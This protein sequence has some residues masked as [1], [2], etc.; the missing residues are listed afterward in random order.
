MLY[1][2]LHRLEKEGLIESAWRASETSRRRKY[3]R[4]RKTGQTELAR[5]RKQWLAVHTTLNAVWETKL[6]PT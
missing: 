4:I 3:Y 1:P 2:V 5:Q 6:C